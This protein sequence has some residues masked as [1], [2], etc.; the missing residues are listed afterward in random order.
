MALTGQY[1]RSGRGIWGTL[2]VDPDFAAHLVREHERQTVPRLRRLWRYFRNPPV[3]GSATTSAGPQSG[4]L[5][6]SEGL[7][8]RLRLAAGRSFP[9]GSQREIVIENDIAW[10]IHTL[11]DFMFG[12]L[13]TLRSC[14]ADAE[15]ARSI[16]GL[17]GEVFEANGGIGFFQDMALLGSVYGHVDVVVRA[18]YATA[19][20]QMHK[21]GSGGA[22]GATTLTGT[23]RQAAGVARSGAQ[24]I[25]LDLIEGPRGLPMLDPHDYRR[26]EAYFLHHRLPLNR[27]EDESLLRR[28]GR[29]ITTPGRDEGRQAAVQRTQIWTARQVVTLED[30]PGATRVID[31]GPNPLGRMPVI[32]I[33][34]MPQPFFYEGISDVEPLIPLQDE[35]NIRL[36][37]RANRVTFQSF[38]MYL[39]KGIE[40]FTQRPIGPGQMWATDNIDASIEEFGGDAASPSEDAHINE[41]REALD[42][43]SG[44]TPLAA[45]VLRN[46]VGHLTSENALRIVLMGLLAKTQRKRVAYGA[47]IER[48][49]ELIL[50][51]ADVLGILPNRPEDRQV[52][53][54][55]P[56]ALPE[57]QSQ[58]LREAQL[59]LD[60]GVPARQ[61]LT[62][63]GYGDCA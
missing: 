59:K 60:L 26:I 35:L 13:F 33:Q 54:E 55:W 11:V 27:V 30:F 47:G 58:R 37:D 62:E 14:A 32:H 25:V 28:W 3:N 7:P 43:T 19:D 29:R 6:H 10:R 38:K 15:L 31:A 9:A 50:H 42:K 36:S 39:G 44:V 5:A 45:G 23:S 12:R 16:E 22:G 56:S 4:A 24:R 34:N 41:I 63:L 2:G 20:S 49:C 48:M 17:L 1:G 21:G 40:Q 51:A 52:R 61:V 8:D 57:S 53:L 46:K 18:A